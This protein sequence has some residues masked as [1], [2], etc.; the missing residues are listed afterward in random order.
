MPEDAKKHERDNVIQ[1]NELEMLGSE[2]VSQRLR[3]VITPRAERGNIASSASGGIL[4]T[5]ILMRS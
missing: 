5:T 3:F 4:A 2:T 1:R